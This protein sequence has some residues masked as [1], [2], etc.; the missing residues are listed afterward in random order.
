MKKIK[1]IA[2]NKTLLEL[3]ESADAGDLIDLQE[4]SLVTKNV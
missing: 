4:V 2:K 1:V 3:L